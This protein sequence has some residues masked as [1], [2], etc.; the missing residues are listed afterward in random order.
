MRYLLI[1]ILLPTLLS[2]RPAAFEDRLHALYP[3]KYYDVQAAAWSA[4][5]DQDCFATDAWHHYYRFADLS[6]QYGTGDYDLTG[7]TTDA[8]QN[9]VEGTFDF[10]LL[11]FYRF[12]ETAEGWEEIRKAHAANPDRSEVYLRL[13]TYY[14]LTGQTMA[15]NE[16]LDKL[17][18][19]DPFPAAVIDYNYNQLMSAPNGGVLLTAGYVETHPT[20]LLQSAYN[21]RPDVRVYHLPTLVANDTVRARTYGELGLTEATRGSSLAPGIVRA[22]SRR[23]LPILISATNKELISYLPKDSLYVSGLAFHYGKPSEPPLPRST[24][25]VQEI[26][27]LESIATPLQDSPAQALADQLNQNYLP[28]LLD[29][30]VAEAKLSYQP[31]GVQIAGLIKVIAERSG[32]ARDGAAFLRNYSRSSEPVQ[33]ASAEPGVSATTI[34]K[35]FHFIPKFTTTTRIITDSDTSTMTS[36]HESFH[37]QEMEVSNGDY[38]V[39]LQDLLRGRKFAYIDSAAIAKV[40]YRSLL[41]DSVSSWSDA[42][43]FKAGHPTAVDHPVANV[44]YRA[45]E[46]YAEWLTQVYNQDPKRKRNVRFRLPNTPQFFHAARGGREH[47]LYPWGGPYVRNAAGCWLANANTMT[48]TEPTTEQNNDYLGLAGQ[49]KDGSARQ[50]R[51][52]RRIQK[53]KEKRVCGPNDDGAWT[54]AAVDAYFP[55]NF[56]L[57]NMSGNVAEMLHASEKAAGGS[58]L[59]P[60][61]DLKIGQLQ[62]YALPHPGV[63]FRLIMEIE[64]ATLR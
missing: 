31:P 33:L 12:G 44:T 14:E 54:T 16:I 48:W 28:T 17:H 40:D 29:I 64:K 32:L 52:E 10:H 39:F 27:R 4:H 1:F 59:D 43:L 2:A 21:V 62:E 25:E 41:P 50:R 6:N 26:W 47:A 20:W 13:A 36:Y 30:Y 11:R 35:W 61:G 5:I 22:I 34:D 3:G 37:M 7:I 42:K 38:Q 24:L 58:W 51:Q 49:A 60:V 45:A 19:V 8:G 18:R 23:R 55:N 63:G 57:N 46:L 15:R 53:L 56:G 9:L